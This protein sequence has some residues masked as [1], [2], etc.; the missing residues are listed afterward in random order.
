MPHENN[1]ASVTAGGDIA[2]RQKT[3]RGRRKGSK[4]SIPRTFA[5]FW[6]E[7]FPGVNR[8]N[9]TASAASALELF[10]DLVKRLRHK[11]SWESAKKT[12]PVPEAWKYPA[13]AEPKQSISPWKHAEKTE[14]RE[15]WILYWLKVAL[16][17][18]A[19]VPFAVASDGWYEVAYGSGDLASHQVE[20]HEVTQNL[21][22]DFQQLRSK[23]WIF[24]QASFDVLLA[25]N[26]ETFSGLAQLLKPQPRCLSEQTQARNDLAHKVY[27]AAE[28]IYRE[29]LHKGPE[30]A[31]KLKQPNWQTVAYRAKP[32][33]PIDEV[34]QKIFEKNRKQMVGTSEGRRDLERVRRIAK[35]IAAASGPVIA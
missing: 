13:L 18:K 15:R 9:L 1:K 22:R 5:S 20:I 26:A 21:Q 23:C 12:V 16:F 29:R 4:D 24:V 28:R 3:K 33:I 10:S 34:L 32:R 25:G 35:Q 8:N 17:S 31:Q 6:D 14:V 27:I 7:A 19:E 30:S 11:K 2:A